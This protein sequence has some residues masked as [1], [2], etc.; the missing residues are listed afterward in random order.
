[1]DSS[2]V[3]ARS[4]RC[5]VRAEHR[6]Y[7]ILVSSQYDEVKDDWRAQVYLRKSRAPTVP[8]S[9][10]DRDA[11]RAGTLEEAIQLGLAIAEQ[12]VEERLGP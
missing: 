3:M 11:V 6:G 8:A 4:G 12:R 10:R 1:M 2:R 5:E 7:R 9:Q